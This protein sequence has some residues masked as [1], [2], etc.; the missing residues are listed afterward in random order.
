MKINPGL[1]KAIR[2]TRA[3][4]KNPL[5]Y[6]LVDQKIPEESSCK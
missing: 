4:V 1:S 6:C 2:V 3:Q 5:G